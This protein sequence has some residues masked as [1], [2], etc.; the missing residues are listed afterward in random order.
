MTE[1]YTP[2]EAEVLHDYAYVPLMNEEG[3]DVGYLDMERRARFNRFIASVKAAELRDFAADIQIPGEVATAM[4]R[5]R[6]VVDEIRERALAE[7]DR[8]EKG[9][10]DE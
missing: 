6:Y 8:I 7:A 3:E 10:G 1:P 9:A 4:R 5:E 2:T